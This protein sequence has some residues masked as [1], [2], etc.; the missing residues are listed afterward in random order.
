MWLEL[1][2]AA[3]KTREEL[4]GRSP[5]SPS[6]GDEEGSP[7]RSAGDTVVDNRKVW[8][9]LLPA[10]GEATEQSVL[11]RSGLEP[12]VRA[13]LSLVD[14]TADVKRGLGV[15]ANFVQHHLGAH[16]QGCCVSEICFC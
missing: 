2:E 15:H 8:T 1:V 12:L 13:Y 10:L 5:P 4:L 6:A 3:S 9:A 7:S 11:R 14:S 16:E